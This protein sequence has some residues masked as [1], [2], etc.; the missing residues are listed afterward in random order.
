M[1]MKAKKIGIWISIG[2]QPAIGLIRYSRYIFIISSF[3]FFG[4]SLYFALSSF[5]CGASACI[6]FMLFVL[7]AVSGQK[8]SLTTTVTP[9]IAQPQLW[10]MLWKWDISH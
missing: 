5:I 8:A 9:M 10:K 6:C 4:S 7:M 2:R 3:I 1:L